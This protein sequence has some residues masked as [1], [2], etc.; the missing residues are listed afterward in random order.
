MSALNQTETQ[1][2]REVMNTLENLCREDVPLNVRREWAKQ[3]S[4]KV[5]SI[6]NRKGHYSK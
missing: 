1:A 4:D 6:V 3:A 2:L 5:K